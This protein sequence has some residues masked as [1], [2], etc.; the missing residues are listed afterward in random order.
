MNTKFNI[1]DKVYALCE[2]YR[3]TVE[4]CDFCEGFGEVEIPVS[5]NFTF[6]INEKKRKP[7]PICNGKKEYTKGNW[8]F[9]VV[10][11]I[12]D[13]ISI[14]KNKITY[15]EEN[16]L[17]E[18]LEEDVFLTRTEAQKECDRRNFGRS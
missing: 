4:T 17:V 7:C 3:T 16:D 5:T 6:C 12:V 9:N 14:E 13:Y 1:K 18:Y 15:S 11:I 8:F 2:E 10:L